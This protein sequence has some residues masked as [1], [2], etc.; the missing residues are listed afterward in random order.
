MEIS[1]YLRMFKIGSAMFL[2]A[3]LDL[4]ISQSASS[5][6]FV[7][8]RDWLSLDS[9]CFH[10]LPTSVLYTFCVVASLQQHASC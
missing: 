9:T 4:R 2:D 10:L 7:F 8:Q 1:F 5:S 3:T 6:F